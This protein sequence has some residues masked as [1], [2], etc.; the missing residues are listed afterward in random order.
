MQ[1]PSISLTFFSVRF[2]LEPHFSFI[3][4]SCLGLPG[5]LSNLCMNQ[6]QRCK[7]VFSPPKTATWDRFPK[8]YRT[9]WCI[10]VSEVKKFSG[11]RSP[12]SRCFTDENLSWKRWSWTPQQTPEE[13]PKKFDRPHLLRKNPGILAPRT[14]HHI[15][16][17]LG[18]F[19]VLLGEVTLKQRQPKC[20]SNIEA[21]KKG[22]ASQK[23]K[24]QIIW[25]SWIY[26]IPTWSL[27]VWDFSTVCHQVTPE[28]ATKVATKAT[29]R[30]INLAICGSAHRHLWCKSDQKNHG[31]HIQIHVIKYHIDLKSRVCVLYI[32]YIYI[33]LI[34]FLLCRRH[35]ITTTR[36][37]FK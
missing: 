1:T 5:Y 23:V 4:Y 7:W 8:I 21:T 36:V 12:K 11:P 3:V 14:H 29:P 37:K 31:Y 19:G 10:W 27:T 26:S 35:K 34:L 22:K 30:T 33:L 6:T 18:V 24:C 13:P 2:W 17:H 16:H 9:L 25:P 15:T 32:C 20:W 28:I